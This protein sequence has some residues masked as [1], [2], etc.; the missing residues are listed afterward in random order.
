MEYL[1]RISVLQTLQAEIRLQLAKEISEKADPQKIDEYHQI[2]K[3]IEAEIDR[4]RKMRTYKPG[5]KKE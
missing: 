4:I 5:I 3:Q 1:Q 2:L